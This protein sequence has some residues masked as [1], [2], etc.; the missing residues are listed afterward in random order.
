MTRNTDLRAI[1][2]NYSL[3]HNTKKKIFY[4]LTRVFRLTPAIYLRRLS[5]ACRKLKLRK[6]IDITGRNSYKNAL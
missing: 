2:M 4:S 1:K 6:G 3:L 5:F